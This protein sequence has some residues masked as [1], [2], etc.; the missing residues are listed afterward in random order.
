LLIL[1][2][3]AYRED[4]VERK[5]YCK[6]ITENHRSWLEFASQLGYDLSLSDLILVYGCDKTSQWACAAWSE[7]TQSVSLSFVAGVPGIAGGGARLWGE[8]I[9][10]QSLD[11]NIGPQPLVPT[12]EGQGNSFL[13]RNA[14]LSD[15][16]SINQAASITTALP[17]PTRLSN[18]CVFVRGY[19]M[20]DRTTWFKRKMTRIDVGSGFK[21]VPKP[22]DSQKKMAKDFDGSHRPQ[23]QGPSAPAGSSQGDTSSATTRA[24]D[25]TY[26]SEDEDEESS[27][28]DDGN[29]TNIDEVGRFCLQYGLVTVLT[30][31]QIST[32][33][34]VLMGYIFQVCPS[35]Y[36]KSNIPD[37]CPM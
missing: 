33:V 16:P 7:Q 28:S 37:A 4:A 32:P 10:Q 34:D 24:M 3:P 30:S 13:Q 8:W 27:D 9:S 11:Q 22:L 17:I 15:T 35:L 29:M 26:Q 2:D 25:F 21:I 19:Q 20:G 31:S 1:G 12:V 36:Y 18:Q 6:Y 14:Q 23:Q 5:Q